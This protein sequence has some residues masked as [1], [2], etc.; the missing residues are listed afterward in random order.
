MFS[1]LSDLLMPRR[2]PRR[3]RGEPRSTHSG[4]V[5]ACWSILRDAA[6]RAAPQDEGFVFGRALKIALAALAIA[7]GA[8]PCLAQAPQLRG[9]ETGEVRALVIGIDA[10]QN[11]RPLKGA[12]ADARDVEGALRGM[13]VRDVTTLLDAQ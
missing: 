8:A 12:V 3:S 7:L 6:L 4:A 10:Y 1:A 9:P 11:V 2:S 5:G 13:G